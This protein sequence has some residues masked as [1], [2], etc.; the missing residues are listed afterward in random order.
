MSNFV[1]SCLTNNYIEQG[2]VLSCVMTFN[3]ILFNDCNRILTNEVDNTLVMSDKKNFVYHSLLKTFPSSS[4][5]RFLAADILL[6]LKSTQK[7]YPHE[8]SKIKF[9]AVEYYQ[10][11]SLI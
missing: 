11:Q 6:A 5:F 2:G 7:Y 3:I 4:I 8:T 1:H 10:L 9:Y